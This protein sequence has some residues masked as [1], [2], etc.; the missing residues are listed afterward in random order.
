MYEW[1]GVA[2]LIA[3]RYA[4]SRAQVL[5]SREEKRFF[6]QII[7]TATRRGPKKGRVSG[8]KNLKYALTP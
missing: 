2:G 6:G 4:T 8:Q 7:L 3:G 1:E 5:K